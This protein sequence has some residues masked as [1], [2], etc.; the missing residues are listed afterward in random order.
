MRNPSRRQKKSLLRSGSATLTPKWPRRR[1]RNGRGMRTPPTRNSSVVAWGMRSGLF[2][3]YFLPLRSGRQFYARR[4]VSPRNRSDRVKAQLGSHRRDGRE[5]PVVLQ[6]DQ[7]VLDRNAGDQAVVAAAGRLAGAT[8]ALIQP[9]CSR[10]VHQD[11]QLA[12]RA[13]L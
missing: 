10:G 6:Q 9:R 4:L 11:H 13:R 12:E 3:V 7:I 5:I 2:M 1:M 8:A